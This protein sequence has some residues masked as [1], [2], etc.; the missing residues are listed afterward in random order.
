MPI[1]YLSGS[2]KSELKGKLKLKLRF[3]L[4]MWKLRHLENINDINRERHK[5]VATTSISHGGTV[6]V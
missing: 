1:T 2:N 5:M 4:L 6:W 3:N